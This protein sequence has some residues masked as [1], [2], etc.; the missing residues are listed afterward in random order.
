[1]CKWFRKLKKYFCNCFY[2]K[3]D[4][5][6]LMNIECEVEYSPAP[7]SPLTTEGGSDDN[8]ACYD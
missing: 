1:M 3:I 5:V 8:L 6:P 4:Y 2:P 7:M